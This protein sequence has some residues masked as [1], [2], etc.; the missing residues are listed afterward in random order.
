[1]PRG[2]RAHKP[3]EKEKCLGGGLVGGRGFLL[4]FSLFLGVVFLVISNQLGVW[5]CFDLVFLFR[6]GLRFD[7]RFGA[8]VAEVGGT[9]GLCGCFR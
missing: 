7:L 2:T 3:P 1:M 5:M 9:L 8:G 4:F 6:F